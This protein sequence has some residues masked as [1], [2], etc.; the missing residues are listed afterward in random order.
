MVHDPSEEGARSGIVNETGKFLLVLAVTPSKVIDV[1]I[2]SVLPVVDKMSCEVK[3]FTLIKSISVCFTS[4]LDKL[5]Y[6]IKNLAF[7]PQTKP[8]SFVLMTNSSFSFEN[9]NF[10][11]SSML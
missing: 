11:V 10:F 6:T 5:S 9:V 1:T 4:E 7:S 3:L 8:V 2:S